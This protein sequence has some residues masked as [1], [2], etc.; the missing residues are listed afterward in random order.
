MDDLVGLRL[1]QPIDESGAG[2]SFAIGSVQPGGGEIFS[3]VVKMFEHP[4]AGLF[5]DHMIEVPGDVFDFTF[6]FFIHAACFLDFALISKIPDD[7]CVLLLVRGRIFESG[8][9]FRELPILG[10]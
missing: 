5:P 8:G 7:E 4:L 1:L 2:F 10:A 6:L 9:L 3:N